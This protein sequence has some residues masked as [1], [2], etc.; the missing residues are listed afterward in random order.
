MILN[1]SK[2]NSRTVSASR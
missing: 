2:W 1:S